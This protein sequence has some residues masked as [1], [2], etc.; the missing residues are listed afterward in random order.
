MSRVSNRDV[1]SGRYYLGVDVGGS[2]THALVVNEDGEALGFGAGGPGNQ[3]GVGYEGLTSILCQVIGQALQQSDLEINQLS[4]AGLGIAGYDWDCQL[5]AHLDAIA[6]LKLDCPVRIVNDAVIGLLA[7]ASQGW[8]ICLVSGTGNNCRGRDRQGREGRV[9]GEG[10]L[11]GEYGGGGDLVARAIACISHQ[12][13]R[14]GR[15][16]ALTELF[17]Q[18]AGARDIYDL[19]EGIDLHRYIPDASWALLVLQAAREGDL[20][21]K[22][23]VVWN[24]HEVAELGCSVIRQLELQAEEFEVVLAGSVFK[25]GSLYIQPL[26][27]RILELAPKARFVPLRVPPVVGGALLAMEQRFGIQVYHRRQRLLQSTSAL[28]SEL[29]KIAGRA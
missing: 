29:Q 15:P 14:R 25:A 6:P 17:M 23:I 3:Q 10:G 26:Q 1:R 7:G 11:F 4:G 22:E 24:A 18:R 5:Q 13:T 16:T 12:W 28:I 20:A 8:G 19:I 9:T 21:A 27:E 2:K